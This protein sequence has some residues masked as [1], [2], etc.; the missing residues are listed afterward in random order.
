MKKKLLIVISLLLV[1]NAFSCERKSEVNSVESATENPTETPSISLATLYN[2]SQTEKN[3][4]KKMSEQNINLDVRFYGSSDTSDASEMLNLDMI[5]GDCP[6]VLHIPAQDMK[7][8]V[9]SG[10]MT[11]LYPLLE[12]SPTLKKDDFLPNVIAGLDVDGKLPAICDGFIL[13]TAVAKTEIVG[14]DAENWSPKQAL[15]L[16]RNTPADTNFLKH[17]PRPSDVSYYLTECLAVEAVEA[18]DFGG[19]YRKMLDFIAETPEITGNEMT[20]YSE[21]GII[22]EV[23]I[24]GINN[25]ISLQIFAD[26]QGKDVTF[27]GYPSEN[28]KG[29][30]AEANTMFGIPEISPNKDTAFEVISLMMTDISANSYLRMGV[31]ALEKRIQDDLKVSKYTQ[32]SINCPI[33]IGDEEVQMPEEK[34]QQVLDYIRNIDFDPYQ[35]NAEISSII[36]QEFWKFLN[37]EITAQECSDTLN[38]RIS[39]Y[40]S[41]TN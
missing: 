13:S 3:L 35:A 8:C 27:V 30:I 25:S 20:E 21:N 1:L 17:S 39:L 19:E 26:F 36:R 5:S 11:D 41:E 28:G 6:D 14:N 18:C 37:N 10:Y 34:I 31:P 12:S 40:L 24:F 2:P 33:N 22:E 4:I 23:T 38:N 29:Y 16:F 9:K 7:I 15:D 32:T